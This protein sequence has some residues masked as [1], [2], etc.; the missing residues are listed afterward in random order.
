MDDPFADYQQDA[1]SEYHM[2]LERIL[3]DY[4]EGERGPD[5]THAFRNGRLEAGALYDSLAAHLPGAAGDHTLRRVLFDNLAPL[6]PV[7]AAALLAPLSEEEAAQKKGSLVVAR[8]SVFTPDTAYALLSS[9]PASGD[10]A[11]W[12]R[13]YAWSQV[14]SGFLERYGSDYLPWVEQLPAGRD[15]EEAA[16]GAL[17][18]YLK[19][20]DLSGYRRIRALVTDPRILSLFPPR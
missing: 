5:L 6:D 14:T 12:E 9:I 1:S 11:R 15:R 7:R 10:S 8:T 2:I 20:G 19:K 4:L 18:S 3:R 17:L 16:A 13:E